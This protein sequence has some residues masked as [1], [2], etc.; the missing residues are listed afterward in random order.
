MSTDRHP[1]RIAVDAM[2]GDY[3]PSE[4]VQGA[5]LAAQEGGVQLLLVGEPAALQKELA[6]QDLSRWPARV[7]P[8]EGIIREDEPPTVALRQKPRASVLVA[9]QL[10]K[11]GQADAF[12]SM[13]STGAAM[14]SAV[15]SL[16]L[17][18]GVERPTVGGAF[19][20]LAPTTVILDLGT[21]VD[22]RPTQLLSFGVIGTVMAQTFA[23]I[24]NP[25]VALL[26]V[27]A[28]ESKGNRQVKETHELFRASSLNFVGNVEGHDLLE[29]RADVV[30]CDGFV[31]NVIMK[32]CEGL[33]AAISRKV[34]EQLSGRLPRQEVD[35]LAGE[36]YQLTNLVEYNGG[37]PLL[38]VK[39]VAIVGHGR[40]RAPA[41][42]NAITLARR[43]VESGFVPLLQE[44]LLALQRASGAS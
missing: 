6:G 33:G 19:L 41:V 7:V 25:R 42:K 35:E 2:G 3:A 30:I 20:G 18:E 26:S 8:S 13:G 23:N 39:G 37:G 14:A 12:V 22:C 29:N 43:A 44:R 36:I 9:A 1:A 38:G 5:L 11:M 28:E 17:L 40:S 21:N 32:L 34:A 4:L 15:F 31:G 16:G 24:A 27:G 10:V